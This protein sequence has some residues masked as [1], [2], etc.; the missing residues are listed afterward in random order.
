ML[1]FTFLLIRSGF[2][3]E[4]KEPMDFLAVPPKR[5]GSSGS[6][7]LR[8]GQNPLSQ[9]GDHKRI[10]GVQFIEP[11]KYIEGGLDESSPYN[12]SSP[13]QLTTKM[14]LCDNMRFGFQISIAGGFSKVAERAKRCGCETI[15]VF[16]SNPRIWEL[17]SL[18][19]W[20]IKKFKK[21]SLDSSLF[22]LFVH[23]SYLPNLAS[24]QHSLYLKSIKALVKTMKRAET[25]G[26]EGLVIHL[27]NHLKSK[28]EEAIKRVAEGINEALYKVKGNLTLLLENTAGQGTEI[29]YKFS[30]IKEIIEKIGDKERIGVCLDTAHAFEAGY[31]LS[32][33]EGFNSTLNEFEKLIGLKRLR[34]IHLNDSKTPLASGKDRHEHI[35]KGY[36]GLS[37][38]YNIV[39]HPQLINLPA[40]M[41]TP[42]KK[43]EDDLRNMKVIRELA[44]QKQLSSIQ[45]KIGR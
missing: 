9:P 12:K 34:L 21:E 8:R 5:V 36:I 29:G 13:Y 32:T 26:A 25:L 10:V 44:A 15:Q 28:K 27:G 41:E 37:G 2:P 7:G 31:D 3:G 23:I 35:G 11:E 39:N 14:E 6:L 42:K 22:P 19:L 43:E 33:K 18:N 20:E 24:P 40:I 1:F 16:S 4:K 38:F 45:N 17:P 30:Q